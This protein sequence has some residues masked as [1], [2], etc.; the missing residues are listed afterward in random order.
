M[1]KFF[2]ELSLISYSMLSYLPS[3]V[4]AS[5]LYLARRVLAMEKPACVSAGVLPS[6]I[7]GMTEGHSLGGAL[8]HINVIWTS[9]IPTLKEHVYLR[10]LGQHA[11]GPRTHI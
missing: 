10:V 1:A 6:R 8:V 7:I 4:A 3:Q 2:L 5:A 9:P 11:S